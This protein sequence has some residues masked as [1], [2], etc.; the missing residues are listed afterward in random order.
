MDRVHAS[1]YAVFL[2]LLF[3]PGLLWLERAYPDTWNER[4][5]LPK[6]EPVVNR[7]TS[8]FTAGLTLPAEIREDLS[9]SPENNPVIISGVSKVAPNVTL[10]IAPGTQIY[11]GEF[12]QLEILGKLQVIGTSQKP[13]LFTTNER[14]ELNQTWNGVVLRPQSEAAIE[15]VDI[16]RASPGITCEPGSRAN[17]SDTRISQGSMGIFTASS[18]CRVINS[19]IVGVK[20]GIIAH[21]VRANVIDSIVSG[22]HSDILAK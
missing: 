11:V 9:L 8:V 6:L 15:H 12:G 18:D 7:H 19:H 16:L 22:T 10:T 14:Y 2:A 13:I 21:G 1:T 3:I 17:I 20:D 4:L 5:A